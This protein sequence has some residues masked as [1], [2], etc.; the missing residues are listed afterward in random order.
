MIIYLNRKEQE[1]MRKIW[2][3]ERKA[4]QLRSLFSCLFVDFDEKASNE[5]KNQVPK[6]KFHL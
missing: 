4:F 6:L 1:K 3:R 2:K 5:K